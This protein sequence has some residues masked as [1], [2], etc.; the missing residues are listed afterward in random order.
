MGDFASKGVAGSG[1]GLG[2]AGTVL[3]VMN[4]GLGNIFGGAGGQAQYETKEASCLREQLATVRAERYADGVAISAF[5]D[6]QILS[7]EADAKINANY[8][9]LAQAIAEMKVNEAVVAS[10]LKCLAVNTNSRLDALRA[11]TQSAIALEGE[12]RAAGD[13]NLYCYV[14][15]TFVPGKLVMPASAICPP[16]VTKCDVTTD[17]DTTTLVTKKQ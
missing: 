8:K 12:R 6:A 1:L 4:G 11:E 3:G 14:N 17:T 16:V 7:K 2:I 15:A 5:R 10:D 13:Q 9:E